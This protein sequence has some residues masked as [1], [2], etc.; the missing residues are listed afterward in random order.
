MVSLQLGL[1]VRASSTNLHDAYKQGSQPRESPEQPGRS[2]VLQARVCFD[3]PHLPSM[4]SPTSTSSTEPCFILRSNVCSLHFWCL[5]CQESLTGLYMCAV[6]HRAH[7]P[8]W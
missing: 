3:S 2:V 8:Q 5:E 6:A 7:W 1:K 4:T